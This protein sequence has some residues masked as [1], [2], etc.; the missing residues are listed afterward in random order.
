MRWC[1]PGRPAHPT[2]GAVRELGRLPWSE[3]ASGTHRRVILIV[4]FV[5]SGLS[6]VVA[7]LIRTSEL[8]TGLP[9]AATGL[10]ITVVVSVVLGGGRLSGGRSSIVGTVLALTVISIIDNGLSLSNVT[11]Y[12]NQVFHAALLML[13]LVIGR[14][15]LRLR[16][17]VMGDDHGLATGSRDGP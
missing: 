15:T 16:R 9:T 14:P 7:G 1:T 2:G 4:L 10:E 12:V 11:S 8:S 6:A 5:V 13:A 17:P 3:R